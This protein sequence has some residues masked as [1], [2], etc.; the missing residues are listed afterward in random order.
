MAH[1][2]APAFVDVMQTGMNEPANCAQERHPSVDVQAVRPPVLKTW[3]L[4]SVGEQ[5][6]L[7]IGPH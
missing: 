4:S 6:W 3:S 2:Q 1:W 7:P 5:A